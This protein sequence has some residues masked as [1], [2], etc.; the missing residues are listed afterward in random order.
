M[1]AVK[2]VFEVCVSVISRPYKYVL[3]EATVDGYVLNMQTKFG[4]KMFAHF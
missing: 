3:L 1:S 2:F 4:V